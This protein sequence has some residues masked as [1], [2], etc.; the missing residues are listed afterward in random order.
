MLC[1][2]P[3]FNVTPVQ[4][5]ETLQLLTPTK[6]TVAY[7]PELRRDDN[8]LQ[9]HTIQK[10]FFA[11]LVAGAICCLKRHSGQMWKKEGCDLCVHE[12]DLHKAF[13][14]FTGTRPDIVEVTRQA[15]LFNACTAERPFRQSSRFTRMIHVKGD[16]G[17]CEATLEGILTW[18]R[19]LWLKAS[20]LKLAAK[21]VELGGS[22]RLLKEKKFSPG[23]CA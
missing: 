9:C 21:A 18:F 23:R 20:R 8:F 3:L 4:G 11:C 15:E 6:C 10:N 5:G 14:I 22:R 13:T 2:Y 19:S 16:G 12:V 1:L 7:I 17:K